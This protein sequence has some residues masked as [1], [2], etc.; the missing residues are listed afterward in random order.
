MRSMEPK[1]KGKRWSKDFEKPIY[2]GWKRRKSYAFDP[3]SSKPVY[4]IDTPPPYVNTPVHIGQATTYV[5]MDFFARFR[6]MTG[7]EVLFPLGL[8]RNGLPIEM[9]AEKRFKVKLTSLG[10]EKAL[11]LCE[12]ILKEASMAST[13]SFLRSGIS[14]N[15][16]DRGN[17]IGDVYH[18]DSPE[19]RSLTQD[20]F[21]DLWKKG[22]IYEDNRLN[23]YCPGCQT[24]IADAEIERKQVETYLN[25]VKFKIKGT[26]KEIIIA[27]TRPEL[28]CTSALVVFNPKDDRYKG[29]A[30]KTA[31][32]PVFD[33]GV[34]IEPDNEADPKFG[35]GLVFMS[36]S[37]GDQDAVRFLRK[38]AI[39]PVPAIG[40]DGRML[41]VAGPLKGLSTREA[42]EKMISLLEEGGHL[43]KKEKFVHSVPI[44][45]RSKDEIEFVAMPELYLKQVKFKPI[46][47]DFAKKINFFA[48]RSRQIMLDWI[49]SVSIDW[50]ISRRRYYATEIPLW[51]CKKCGEPV[52]PP[53]GKYYRPWK[54]Q[55]PKGSIMAV[56][57]KPLKDGKCKCGGKEFRGETRVFDTWFDSS[58]SPLY[59]M[60]WSRNDKFFNKN[61]PCSVRPQGKEIIRTWLY[62]TV[63]KDYLLTD[64]CIFRDAWINYHIVDES[65]KK[66]SKSK[67]NIIDPKD[68][69]ERF[70]AEPFR[71]WTA[72]E[73]NLTKKDFRCS[74]D[75]I[76]G[77]EK[78]LTK[79]WNISRFIS[80]FP[81]RKDGLSQSKKAVKPS[82]KPTNISPLDKW[83]IHELD[84]IV[85]YTKKQYEGYDF[86]GPSTMIKN[87][88]WEAF[89]SHYLELVK[90]RAY[91]QE[92]KFSKE[93]QASALYTLHHCLDVMLKL[94]API[95]PFITYRIYED[96]HGRDIHA[97][98]FPE[99][100]AATGKAAGKA[101]R[102]GFSSNDLMG[103]NSAIWKAKKDKGLSL[104]TEIESATLP[105]KLK[106]IEKDLT[107]THG[108]KKVK[109][110]KKLLL[111][112]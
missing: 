112:I 49:D 10:R 103:L 28:L 57:K 1:I 98:K 80:M 90:H 36:A 12:S 100:A 82:S 111:S 66:M 17:G 33:I 29:L 99:P 41:D 54:E 31:I 51:Y 104:K 87:F 26:G 71:L 89:A 86:N 59:I 20:T 63:L 97:E 30:G 74:F 58:I 81:K 40:K 25:Y 18:T 60:K 68:V 73:G 110:G 5:L 106:P 35:T 76:Q 44:C 101:A 79:L 83:V 52:L 8:D 32:T 34:K 47:R 46:M 62:Y 91:N 50:P 9:A 96:L 15:S 16:W 72:I 22:L 109:W 43:Q 21:I 108:I 84:N 45:E 92:R 14:F 77:T 2:E 55:P 53:K 3:K 61:K 65:G 11:H 24:T 13:D 107:L 69:L 39:K 102:P 78:T 85:A 42:R 37:A 7:H 105:E 48:P 4:S 88:L 75:R 38:K 27:T 95:V 67:G 94:L 19:Y 6:R 93:Q 64:E 23:N 56:S 70:G